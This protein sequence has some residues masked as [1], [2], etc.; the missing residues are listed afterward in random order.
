MSKFSRRSF[1]TI[2]SSTLI[3]AAIEGRTENEPVCKLGPAITKQRL[4]DAYKVRVDAAAYES[5]FAFPLHSCNGDELRYPSRLGNF[6]KT[7]DHN[8]LGEV[9]SRSYDALLRAISSNRHED[10]EEIPVRGTVKLANPQAA[11]S[12]DLIGPDCQQLSIALPPSFETLEQAGEMAEV[13]WHAVLRDIPFEQYE[14]TPLCSEAS[15]ELSKFPGFKGPRAQG[16]VTPSTLFRG[17]TAGDLRGP[18]ISQFLWKDVPYG[19]VKLVQKMRTTLPNSDYMTDYSWWLAVQNGMSSGN[20]ALDST[21]RYIRN[22]RDLGEYVHKDFTYQA[23]LNACLILLRMGARMDQSNPYLL[24]HSVIQSGFVTHG[25]ADILHHVAVVANLA[26][27]AAWFHKWVVHRRIRPEEFAGRVHNL[28]LKK[29]EYPIAPLL[30]SCKALDIIHERTQTYLLP[31]AYPEGC[32]TH[33]SYPAGHAAIAGACATVLKA[34][35]DEDFIIPDPVIP[36]QEGQE[37]IPLKINLSLGGELD[38][39]A[40]N[41]SIGRN[42][43]G[44]HW[45]SDAVEGMKLGEEVA[46]RFLNEMRFTSSELFQGFNLTKFNGE[47]VRI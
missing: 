13:Y 44:V 34:F 14:Q 42:F 36:G 8:D 32:P 19:A 5:K 15:K 12:F 27:K 6:S 2:L 26:L 33:P 47:K 17:E 30:L 16:G 28:I 29:A 20:V 23:F 38:K 43:A 46:I 10:F 21:P 45:R 4:A 39:L 25:P 3:P 24:S 11:Y 37:L 41:I 31:M 40:S 1:L 7:L 35:F 9:Q 18:Y 22:G